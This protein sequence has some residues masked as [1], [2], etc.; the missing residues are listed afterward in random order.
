M[1]NN[2]RYNNLV[3]QEDNNQV[4]AFEDNQSNRS[5]E[6]LSRVKSLLERNQRSDKILFTGKFLNTNKIKIALKI[7]L[8]FAASDFELFQQLQ[9]LLCQIDF[10]MMHIL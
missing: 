8:I 9:Q 2:F 6:A 5:G 3:F 7:I 4:D 10:Q 1:S